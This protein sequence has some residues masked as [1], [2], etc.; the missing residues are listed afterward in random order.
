[1]DPN[2]LTISLSRWMSLPELDLRHWEMLVEA[3]QLHNS[4]S[5]GDEHLNVLPQ[6]KKSPNKATSRVSVGTVAAYYKDYVVRQGLEK[7]FR[8]SVIIDATRIWY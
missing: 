4:M 8:W 6:D 7:Y 1:M 3:E 2:V 5:L